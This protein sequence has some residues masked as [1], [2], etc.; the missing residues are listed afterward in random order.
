MTP[1]RRREVDERIYQQ[2]RER[3]DQLSRDP[4]FKA[5]RIDG[6]M[7]TAERKRL[8]AKIMNAYPDVTITHLQ[9]ILERVTRDIL[10]K[11]TGRI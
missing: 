4:A 1:T 2:V 9:R 3:L 8:I 11:P 5:E 6:P 7:R 10:H